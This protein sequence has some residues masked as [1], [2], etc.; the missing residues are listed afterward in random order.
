MYIYIYIYKYTYTYTY[1]SGAMLPTSVPV[2]SGTWAYQTP[3]DLYVDTHNVHGQQ[4]I[5]NNPF[6]ICALIKQSLDTHQIHDSQ[7]HRDP[8]HDVSSSIGLAL[9][10]C[11]GSSRSL[12]SMHQQ[13][14][15]RSRI[16]HQA[17]VHEQA[18]T[19][20]L[21]K[22]HLCLSLSI[23]LSLYIYIYIHV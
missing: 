2:M 20:Q 17:L 11:P 16:Y 4:V 23:Y 15:T 14:P 8:C 22:G 19:N 21:E 12:H 3:V 7:I 9:D 5:A 18:S 10:R 1:T 13:C 6:K